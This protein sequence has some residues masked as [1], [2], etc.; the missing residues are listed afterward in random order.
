MDIFNFADDLF[1]Y[2]VTDDTPRYLKP[3]SAEKQSLRKI[4]TKLTLEEKRNK[5]KRLAA[6]KV[7]DCASC[8]ENNQCEEYGGAYWCSMCI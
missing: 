3:L 1:Q 4:K 8:G 6:Y 7:T 5:P 2:F